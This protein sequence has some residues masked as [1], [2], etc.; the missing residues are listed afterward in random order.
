M[1]RLL[2][3]ACL[4]LACA[5]VATAL[6]AAKQGQASER[7]ALTALKQ[8]QRAMTKTAQAK[9]VGRQ[10]RKLVDAASGSIDVLVKTFGG[11]GKQTA[12]RFT[13]D[14]QLGNVVEA[15][16]RPGELY[17]NT[18]VDRDPRRGV[19]QRVSLNG[20]FVGLDVTLAKYARPMNK[21]GSR[22]RRE[23]TVQLELPERAA[24]TPLQIKEAAL[25]GT[26]GRYRPE[27]FYASRVLLPAFGKGK[28]ATPAALISTSKTTHRRQLMPAN[29]KPRLVSFVLPAS[30]QTQIQEAI[31]YAQALSNGRMTTQARRRIGG[32]L[33][34][35]AQLGATASAVANLASDGRVQRQSG[36]DLFYAKLT[37]VDGS[38]LELKRFASA[39]EWGQRV[40]LRLTH[41]D[42]RSTS[43]VL[44]ADGGVT[45]VERQPRQYAKGQGWL[46]ETFEQRGP[47]GGAKSVDVSH[48]TERQ[49]PKTAGDLI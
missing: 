28:R 48:S 44:N 39:F 17:L 6:P 49:R 21:D 35:L 7:S 10:M 42:R 25:Q 1:M 41:G 45:L 37:F 30:E 15:E 16:L 8:R 43:L 11:I 20:F 3:I 5:S 4:F 26:P 23:L 2:Q 18:V 13:V 46:I 32:F 31:A 36:G 14:P 19:S 38:T 22:V 24:A 12:V 34:R 27:K 40:E 47:L 29:G 33:R 9:W